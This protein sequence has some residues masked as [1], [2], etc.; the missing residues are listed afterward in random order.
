[1]LAELIAKGGDPA[2]IAAGL[3]YEQMD[4]SALEAMVDEVIAANPEEWQRYRGGDDKVAQFLLGQ[5]MRASKG[6]ANGKLVAA[7]FVSR[8]GA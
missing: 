8:R 6:R 4:A 1:M 3:G 5:V 2:R 7:A